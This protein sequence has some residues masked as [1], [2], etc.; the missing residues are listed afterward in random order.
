MITLS[1]NIPDIAFHI[2][3]SLSIIINTLTNR[4]DIAFHIVK[5]LTIIVKFLLNRT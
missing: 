4:P 5:S 3:K 2:V 1:L